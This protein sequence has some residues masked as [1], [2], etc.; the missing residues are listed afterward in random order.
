M[1]THT[2]QKMIDEFDLVAVNGKKISIPRLN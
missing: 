1:L 2:L